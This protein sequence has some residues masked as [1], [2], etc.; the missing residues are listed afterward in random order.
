M[1]TTKVS[2]REDEFVGRAVE[3]PN[4]PPQLLMLTGYVGKSSKG[5]HTRIY[6]DLLL[7]SYVDVPD[8]EILHAQELPKA[9][10]PVGGYYIW[11]RRTDLILEELQ[12]GYQ[13]AA[14]AQQDL[15]SKLQGNGSMTTGT[16]NFNSSS[17]TPQY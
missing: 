12:Q 6:L 13:R 16:L 17:F 2:L 8:E 15:V 1:V 3:D 14:Q 5:S 11:I 9:Q 7:S 4:A 10:S